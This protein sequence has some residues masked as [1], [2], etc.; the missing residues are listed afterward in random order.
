MNVHCPDCGALVSVVMPAGDYGSELYR[1]VT[2][3]E[4]GA[5]FTVHLEVKTQCR[6]PGPKETKEC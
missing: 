5:R 3:P 2:C 4:C 6:T 1:V